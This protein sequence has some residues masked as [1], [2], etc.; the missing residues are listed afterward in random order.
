M[1]LMNVLYLVFYIHHYII[2]SEELY[3]PDSPLILY[4]EK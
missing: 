3:G 2:S 1:D 4:I